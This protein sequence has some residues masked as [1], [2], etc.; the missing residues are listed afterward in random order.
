MSWLHAK[1]PANGIPV[2][3]YNKVVSAGVIAEGS[4]PLWDQTPNGPL[5]F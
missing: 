1:A 4:G 3:V 2:R 5:I